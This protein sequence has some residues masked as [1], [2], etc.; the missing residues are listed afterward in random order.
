MIKVYI[1]SAEIRHWVAPT[2][3]NKLL[4]PKFIKNLASNLKSLDFSYVTEDFKLRDNLNKASAIELIQKRIS[5][6]YQKMLDGIEKQHNFFNK[7][8]SVEKTINESLLENKLENWRKIFKKFGQGTMINLARNFDTEI[9]FDFENVKDSDLVIIRNIGDETSDFIKY[10]LSLQDPKLIF[11]DVAYY[12]PYKNKS[13]QRVGINGFVHSNYK[14]CD[15]SRLWMFDECL[16]DWKD[17]NGPILLIPPEGFTCDMYNIDTASW[18]ERV[19][20][21]INHYYKD[22]EIITRY[23]PNKKNRDQDS[24][25]DQCNK[26][27]VSA[28]VT[29]SSTAALQTLM[30]GIPSIATEK[31]P[32]SAYFDGIEK[33]T[34]WER[35]DRLEFLKWLSHCQYTVDEIESG[36]S[37]LRVLKDNI[38]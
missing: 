27:E 37:I 35:K 8:N 33:I 1:N 29:H 18:I 20:S 10:R 6:K 25:E 31:C 12:T 4:K 28:V 36:E 19:T 34:N 9:I 24:L 38:S 5:K 17:W 22:K 30:W 16:Q 2:L 11:I 32:I 7:E 14:K 15:D 23:K 13:I 3:S 26:L 21:E